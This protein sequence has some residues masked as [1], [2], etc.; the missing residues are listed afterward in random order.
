MLKATI[1][2]YIAKVISSNEVSAVRRAAYDLVN[3]FSGKENIVE[4]YLSATDPYS[5]LLLH[6][7]PGFLSRFNIGA[8]FYTVYQRQAGMYPES[9]LW[10]QWAIDD[11]QQLANLYK[12][13]LKLLPIMPSD[14]QIQAAT[15][16]LIEAES[17]NNYLIE[18]KVILRSLWETGV[19]AASPAAFTDPKIQSRLQQNDAQLCK[20]GHYLGGM[21]YYQGEWYWGIDRIDHLE[22]RLINKGLAK[23]NH[24]RP[25]FTKTYADFCHSSTKNPS[26]NEANTTPLECYFSMRSPYSYLGLTRAMT[27]TQHY[28]IPLIVKPVLPMI[29][30]GMPVPEKK[31]MYI[32]LDTKREAE[33][34]GIDYGFVADPLGVGVERCYALYEYACAEGKGNQFLLTYARAVNAEGIRSETDSGLK[35]IVERAGLK[36][37][38]ANTLLGD[39]SW[40]QWADDNLKE[41]YQLGLWGVPSFRYGEV[42]CWGQDRLCLVENEIIRKHT[43]MQTTLI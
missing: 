10:Q 18:A 39:P 24:E 21:L 6:F 15:A 12:T 29:M 42:I 37:A 23:L 20:Q 2:P 14:E 8:T 1:M 25:V 41:M 13:G 43:M 11:C 19:S 28:K 40:R 34:L 38:K 16:A 3:R 32:F 5:Y 26:S 33:K 31:K 22:R 27:L 35:K 36:W 9:E 17:G 4:I 7:L 30:R